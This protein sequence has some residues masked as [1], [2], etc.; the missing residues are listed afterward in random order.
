MR[1]ILFAISCGLAVCAFAAP[2]ISNVS[3]TR[4]S[5]FAKKV[6]VGYDLTIEDAIVTL[7][8]LTN[9]VS[10][11]A[12]N[13]VSVSGDVNRKI[14]KGVG[15]SIVWQSY[16]D[17]PDHA[18]TNEVV[19]FKLTAWA[20]DNPPDVM[21]VDLTSKSNIAFYASLD[22]M[23]GGGVTNDIYKTDKLVMR[24]IPA[25]G[26][27]FTMG[28][29]G[30]T[31]SKFPH[32][33]AFT[34]DFYLGVYEFTQKQLFNVMGVRGSDNFADRTDSDVLPCNSL[35]W[36]NG[37]DVLSIRSW[38]QNAQTQGRVAKLGLSYK[39]VLRNLCLFSGIAFDLPTGAQWEFACRAGTNTK[40]ND[41]SVNSATMND[42]GWHSG[43]AG[44]APHPVGKKK[45]NAFGLYDMHGNVMEWVL[46]WEY[47]ADKNPYTSYDI[48]P[49][50][51]T[52]NANYNKERR[53][54]GY[55]QT[56]D[57]C[58]STYRSGT[59]VYTGNKAGFR[60]WAPVKMW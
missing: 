40:F 33:V 39:S 48:N 21:V 15:K 28:E 26:S 42:L 25:G 56:A 54:G 36:G 43:N 27:V 58:N 17:W 52:S 38:G 44:G 51:P 23:P 8:V 47:S 41:G 32:F 59:H 13:V 46:D 6:T 57:N 29:A 10:I 45:P 24:R 31:G 53:G 1:N 49:T 30:G 9:G 7:D 34:N 5:A 16:Q 20:L 14:V 60:A 35:P 55:A 19:Q 12:A 3:V 18:I 22:S 37:S 2:G 4:S 11:G 50:G